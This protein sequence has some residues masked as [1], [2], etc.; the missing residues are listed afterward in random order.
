MRLASVLAMLVLLVGLSAG[1]YAK[2]NP[3]GDDVDYLALA[4][5]LF[6]DGHA[7]RARDALDAVSLDDDTL[8]LGQYYVLRGLIALEQTLYV[9]A[10]TALEKSI[11]AGN[12]NPLVLLNLARAH[13]GTKAYEKVLSALDRAGDAALA[14]AQAELLRTQAEWE[15]GRPDRALAVLGRATKRFPETKELFRMELA[16][17]IKLELYQELARKR[18]SFLEREDVSPEDIRAVA[19]ALRKSG[20][21]QRAKETL[22]GARLRFPRDV[23]LTVQLARVFM[24]EGEFVSAGLL[25][26][27][28]ARMDAKYFVEAAEMYRRAGRLVRA[29]V[30][31]KRV[32]GQERKMRQRLQILLQLERFEMIAGMEARLSRLGLLKDQQIRYALAYGYFQLR[33]F[34]STRKHLGFLTDREIFEKA[35]ALRKAIEQ[36]EDAGWQCD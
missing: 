2:K 32:P 25:L 30:I 26:E 6:Q 9:E 27:D 13:F 7:D 23:G 24:D 15:L 10:A 16:L 11:E 3:G 19:E 31:N 20:R 21:P 18:T 4:S 1:A 36:C 12:D 17:L 35:I 33:D 28:A 34:E 8:D 14:E 5:R 22:E 29:L